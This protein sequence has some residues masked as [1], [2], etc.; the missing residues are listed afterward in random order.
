M[1][2]PCTTSASTRRRQPADGRAEPQPSQPRHPHQRVEPQQ[3]V[4]GDALGLAGVG[5]DPV[6]YHMHVVAAVGQAARA[7]RSV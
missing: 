3:V 7:Q 4:H 1:P 2:W 6:G 5:A